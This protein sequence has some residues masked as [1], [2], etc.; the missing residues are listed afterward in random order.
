MVHHHQ[1]RTVE[2]GILSNPQQPHLGMAG[3]CLSLAR[4]ARRFLPHELAEHVHEALVY[5]SA[6][7]W[8]HAFLP[9]LGGPVLVSLPE[10]MHRRFDGVYLLFV[11]M[12]VSVITGMS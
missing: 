10:M 2:Q 1:F 7:S 8:T 3:E 6:I 12:Y 5:I 9:A 11:W 4:Q